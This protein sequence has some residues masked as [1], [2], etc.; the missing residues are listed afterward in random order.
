MH[1]FFV[2]HGREQ[3][4]AFRGSSFSLFVGAAARR[5]GRNVKTSFPTFPI[6]FSP[7]F[8]RHADNGR[9]GILVILSKVTHQEN[10]FTCHPSLNQNY[11]LYSPYKKYNKMFGC[12]T[13][14][15]PESNK[16]K[17]LKCCTTFISLEAHSQNIC[18][19]SIFI[20]HRKNIVLLYPPL[21]TLY[22]FLI[23]FQFFY[24]VY[25]FP[26]LALYF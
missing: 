7:P 10:P 15:A 16:I 6:A 24:S 13:V 19:C 22:L 18:N 2:F 17:L 1:L 14:F 4:F 8:S 23:L 20:C 25:L 3:F 5:R 26:L 11:S 12:L 21:N 9:S